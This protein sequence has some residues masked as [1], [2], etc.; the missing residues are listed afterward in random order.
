MIHLMM[1]KMEF[2]WNYD[3]LNGYAKIIPPKI[4][5]RI[6]RMLIITVLQLPSRGR[7]LLLPT[8]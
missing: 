1:T 6:S 3:I 7:A 2:S 8:L 4:P 5:D